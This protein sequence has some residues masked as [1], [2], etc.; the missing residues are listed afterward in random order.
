MRSDSVKKKQAVLWVVLSLA[1][2]WPSVNLE[3]APPLPG[4]S[5]RVDEQV[6]F[7]HRGLANFAIQQVEAPARALVLNATSEEGL[8]RLTR[9]SEW[10]PELPLVHFALAGEL[11][12]MGEYQAALQ[13]GLRGVAAVSDHVEGRFWWMGSLGVLFALMMVDII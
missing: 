2:L 5:S 6:Y 3:A 7:D 13:A 10:S 9:A 4:S 12:R 8:A 1:L 11:G